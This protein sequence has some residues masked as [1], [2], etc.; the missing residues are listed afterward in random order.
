MAA[1]EGRAV[2]VAVSDPDIL[3]LIPDVVHSKPGD[4][5]K[6]SGWRRIANIP[7]YDCFVRS[8]LI[9]NVCFCLEC[10]QVIVLGGTI[11]NLGDHVGREK[12]IRRVNARNDVEPDSLIERVLGQLSLCA[13]DGY[14]FSHMEKKQVVQAMKCPYRMTAEVAAR[15]IVLAGLDTQDAIAAEFN[16]AELLYAAISSDGWSRIYGGTRFLGTIARGYT[17]DDRLIERLYGLRAV[18]AI[19]G[20]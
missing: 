20:L 10:Q 1:E 6:A 2:W 17:A 5:P 19:L 7:K 16:G 15:L 8:N 13:F 4:I 14:A 9:D 11:G 3:E 12:H 18:D